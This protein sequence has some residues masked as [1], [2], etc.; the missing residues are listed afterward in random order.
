MDFTGTVAEWS[1]AMALAVEVTWDAPQGC[2]SQYLEISHDGG[3]PTNVP[4]GST[5]GTYTYSPP[6][7]AKS[8]TVERYAVYSQFPQ[9]QDS[10]TIHIEMGTMT[11]LKLKC[12]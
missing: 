2:D 5:I 4:L 7:G 1:V 12:T 10:V 9:Y 11:V 8:A 6:S 3:N